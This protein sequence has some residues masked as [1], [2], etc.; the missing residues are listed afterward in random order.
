[1][2]TDGLLPMVTADPGWNGR[3]HGRKRPQARASARCIAAAPSPPRMPD[4]LDLVE[5]RDPDLSG[6]RRAPLLD[7]GVWLEALKRDNVE[8]VTDADHRDHAATGSV[9]ADG[10]EPASSTCIIYGTGFHASE[11]PLGP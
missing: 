5:K 4:R 3:A 7:N 6:G 2:V 8:L 9:T 11:V 1:M 10:D